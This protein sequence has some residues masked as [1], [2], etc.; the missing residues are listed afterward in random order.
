MREHP[1]GRRAALGVAVVCLAQLGGVRPQEIV[2]GVPAGLVLGQQVRARQLG[3]Q[4]RRGFAGTGEAGGGRHRDVR[5]GMQR[6]QPE[7][8]G[9]GRAEGPVGPGE[10]GAQVGAALGRVAVQRAPGPA[11]LL[12]DGGQRE[13]GMGGHPGGHDRHRE[14]QPRAE[15]DDLL[16]R[17]GLR[18]E[19]VRSDTPRQQVVALRRGEHVEGEGMGALRRHQSGQRVA[20]GHQHDAHRAAR[21][22]R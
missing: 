15:A 17:V 7:E 20:A 2:H 5:A 12:G 3:E 13:A 9:R 1:V 16:H 8:A 10:D 19:P 4:R 11:Q 18:Y 22:Q 14:R 21:Q 6:E